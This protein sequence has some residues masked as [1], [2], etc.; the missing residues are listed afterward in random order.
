M[1]N[2][3]FLR[4]PCGENLK[5]Q[6]I[7]PTQNVAFNGEETT[8]NVG[9]NDEE[10][11][12][13]VGLNNEEPNIDSGESEHSHDTSN[14]CKLHSDFSNDNDGTSDEHEKQDFQL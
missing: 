11:I 12:Q 2:N 14:K 4:K 7:K 10:R 5:M 13:N 3:G 6:G 1:V 8:E 9:I